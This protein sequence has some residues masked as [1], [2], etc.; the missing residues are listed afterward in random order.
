MWL[1]QII[2]GD[3]HREAFVGEMFSKN[4]Q[5]GPNQDPKVSFV[6]GFKCFPCWS[7]IHDAF[8][9]HWSQSESE[10][11]FPS[12]TTS[13]LSSLSGL[14]LKLQDLPVCLLSR[15]RSLERWDLSRNQL[16]ELPPNLDLPALR[17]LDLSDNQLEDISSL[18]SLQRLEELK[19]EDNLY[20]TVRKL[21]MKILQAR[22]LSQRRLWCV[23]PSLRSVTTTSS[24]SCCPV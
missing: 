2:N 19:M 21:A 22:G 8:M 6:I 13:V 17:Y 9:Q 1:F 10:P 5:T 16:Q 4:Q 14:K 24:W 20:I 11:Q 3:N 7:V 15:L 18:E 12:L 23:P